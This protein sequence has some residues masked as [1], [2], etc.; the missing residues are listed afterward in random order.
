M[1]WGKT[2]RKL[3]E[4][5]FQ[6]SFMFTGK[7]C[8]IYRVFPYI[9]CPHT[10][11]ASPIINISHESTLTHHFHPNPWVTLEFVLGV[12]LSMGLEM[13]LMT[14]SHCSIIQRKFAALKS[15]CV[16]LVI[17]H[18]PKPWQL[19]IPILSP[20]FCPFQVVIQLESDSTQPFQ[21]VFFH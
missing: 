12:I 10:C 17:P 14:Y 21:I 6:S 8:R 5:Y 19:L 1:D 11:I 16:P 15:L 18:P 3:Q 7:L 13:F 20:Q 2:F 4:G 9:S